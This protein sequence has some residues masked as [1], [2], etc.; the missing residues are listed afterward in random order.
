MGFCLIYQN[1]LIRIQCSQLANDF[2]SY[3]SR[4]SVTIT[5]RPSIWAVILRM[6]TCTGSLRTNL[7]FECPL[8]VHRPYN[9]LREERSLHEYHER[10]VYPAFRNFP[11]P[12]PCLRDNDCIH[13]LFFRRSNSCSSLGYTL[14]PI[15][16]LP[17]I[18]GSSK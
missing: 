3:S 16:C 13:F 1:Q 8:S 15:V 7:L 12:T 9:R 10:T 2:P 18:S 17:I 11:N 14:H 5:L 4:R 6:S